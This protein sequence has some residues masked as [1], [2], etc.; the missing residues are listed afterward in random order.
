[1]L[2]ERK[3]RLK[4]VFPGSEISGVDGENDLQIPMST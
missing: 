1:M 4:N 3:S 2:Q